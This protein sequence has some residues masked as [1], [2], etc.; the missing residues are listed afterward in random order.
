MSDNYDPATP[1]K[2][3]ATGDQI[4][5][6]C[7]W[8]VVKAIQQASDE[9]IVELRHR[10]IARVAREFA[11][12]CLA[13]RAAPQEPTAWSI[14]DKKGESVGVIDRRQDM[15]ERD[16]QYFNNNPINLGKPYTVAPLFL[17]ASSLG[18]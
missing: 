3:D 18:P 6:R 10:L 16:C 11:S 2:A 1:L 7:D 13:D 15:V 17:G 12:S 4:G 14:F 9:S 5:Q 8:L